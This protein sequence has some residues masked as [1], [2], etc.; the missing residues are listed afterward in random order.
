MSDKPNKPKRKYVRK[1]VK[2]TRDRTPP[3]PYRTMEEYINAKRLRGETP[4]Q[5]E[6]RRFFEELGFK[7][8][9][10]PEPEE[11]PLNIDEPEPPAIAR[12]PER[13]SEETSVGV[14]GLSREDLS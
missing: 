11:L 6:Y 12:T 14:R 10:I 2:N 9:I 13:I 5:E 4:T 8:G 3:Y 7:D 1:T